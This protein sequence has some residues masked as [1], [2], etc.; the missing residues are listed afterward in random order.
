[1]INKLLYTDNYKIIYLLITVY[2]KQYIVAKKKQKGVVNLWF[3][4]YSFNVD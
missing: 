2:N 1:M 3:F 4:N